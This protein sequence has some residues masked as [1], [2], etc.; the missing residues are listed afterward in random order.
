VFQPISMRLRTRCRNA[1][2]D[3]CSPEYC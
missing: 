2:C 3:V 1:G